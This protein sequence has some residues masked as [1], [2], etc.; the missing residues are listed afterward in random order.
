MEIIKPVSTE[1]MSMLTDKFNKVAFVVSDDANKIE[2]R[3]AV[4][5]QYNVKVKGVNT[6]RYQGKVKSRYT[7]T[8]VLV[9]RTA[10]YKKAIVTLA[11][12]NSIDFFSNI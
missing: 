4:E 10:K 3:K 5:A 12:G 1:K 11:E 6:V 8:G 7:K 2:I 9:G